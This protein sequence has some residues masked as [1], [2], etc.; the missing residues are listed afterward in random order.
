MHG[1]TR[2][3]FTLIE[4]LVV[5]AIIAILIALLLPAVQQARE[6]ARRTQCRNNLK[7]L[8]LAMHNYHDNYNFLPISFMNGSGPSF[9]DANQ[10]GYNWVRA[11]LP[12]IDQANLSN[13]WTETTMYNAVAGNTAIIRTVIPA[14]LCPSDTHTKTWNNAPNYNYTVNLGNTTAGRTSPFNGVTYSAAPFYYST[15]T[16]GK[17]YKF[18]DFGDG[19]SNVMLMSEV[20]QGQNGSDLRGLIW[21]GHYN[22][23]TAHN[24]PNT[25]VPDRGSGGFCVAANSAIGLPCAATDAANPLMMSSRSRHT[26]GVHTLLGDGSV[27]FI[28]DNIEITTWRNLS[29]IYDGQT[30][31][32][33]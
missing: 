31:G 2:Q 17:A 9:T 5:I 21:Y 18:S 30:L 8:G 26:G 20:R 3:G 33:F 28:S 15:S 22:G 19:V 16:T 14:F 6:A 32:E 12:Y 29:T 13:G 1:R 10:S 25:S 23:F 24:P 11:I 27:R 4:L 7:Q